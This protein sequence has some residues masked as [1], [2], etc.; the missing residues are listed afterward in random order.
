MACRIGM[1][2][3]VDARVIELQKAYAVPPTA[4]Y[5]ILATGLTYGEATRKE[6]VHRA[7][8]GQHCKGTL[9]GKRVA[10]RIWSVYRIDW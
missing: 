8:C 9:A 1:A 3:D 2:T 6:A 7:N 10:G 4:T 5:R